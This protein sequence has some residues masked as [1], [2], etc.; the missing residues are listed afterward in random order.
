MNAE[1]AVNSKKVPIVI[2]AFA[3][4][5]GIL[6][7]PAPEAIGESGMRVMAVAAFML[8]LWITEAIPIPVTAISPIVL[9]PL[10][11]VMNIKEATAGYSHPIVF[12]FMGGF[13]IALAME[14]WKLHLRI[15]LSILRLT[16]THPN[17]I[18]AGFMLATAFLSMW[19]SNT[20]T[21]VMMLPIALSVLDL[22]LR[23]DMTSIGLSSGQ[24]YFAIALM[25]GIA[26]AAN[27]GGTA[28][29]IGTPPNAILAG[30]MQDTYN[31]TIEFID[32]FKLG[33]PFAVVMLAIC[34]AVLVFIVFPN[35]L[36]H[37]RNADDIL[38][39]QYKDLGNIKRE[40]VLVLA[41]LVTTASLWMFKNKLIAFLA[42]L[43]W[44]LNNLTDTGIAVAA[45]VA[46]FIIPTDRK[47]GEFILH[48]RDMEKLPWGILL[49]FGGGLTLAGAMQSSGLIEL[50]G[51]Q[52]SGI[53]TM[54]LVILVLSA[55]LI[56]LIMTE[57]MSNLALITIF[58]PV[59]SG[60][61]AQLGQNPLLFAIPAT[62]ASSCAFMLP[63]ATP[64]N[65]IVFASGYIRVFQMTKA[66]ILM[67]ILAISLITVLAFTLLR[68]A[69]DVK[70]DEIPDWA[71]Q[72]AQSTS[73][74][75]IVSEK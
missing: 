68:F 36:G 38:E 59:L 41:V 1:S 35:R 42:S 31:F 62:L 19:M 26:Y 16:G 12:L 58:L 3:L 25:I 55:A 21:T 47:K 67:N 44:E 7:L 54:G 37:I 46:L 22:T 50:V 18:I 60:V 15:A 74:E 30:Y 48:W 52:L 34:W 49:L 32:W 69:F 17:G 14:K 70:R 39:S 23:K 6:A 33:F 40:E 28:T 53:S 8:T 24:Q 43:G 20:A 11:D 57:F 63:M 5:F 2:F 9:F 66:G 56:V 29:L 64:P 61:A 13:V 45:A 51:D 4:L 27:I 10:L 65:A 75:S 71:A 72:K 73:L